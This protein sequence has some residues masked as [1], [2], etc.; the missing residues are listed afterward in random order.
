MSNKRANETKS[1]LH[2]W[3]PMVVLKFLAFLAF[4][5]VLFKATIGLG[6]QD[7]G[8]SRAW[9]IVAGMGGL[10]LLLAIDRL[11]GLKLSPTGMEATLSETKVQALKEVNARVEAPNV[12]KK[13][14]VD[15]LQAQHPAQVQEAVQEAVKLNVIQTV[16]AVEEAIRGKHK[17]YVRYR[18]DPAK[19]V[20][21]YHIAPRE[22]KPGAT[23]TTRDNDYLWAYS[24]EHESII[25]LRLDRVVG[26]E[27]SEETFDPAKMAAK[28][29]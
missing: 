12:V 29:E 22:I 23:Q 26:V 11:T 17:C 16:E 5:F 28:W 19:P 14:Q 4:A 21:T 18:P 3:L 8:S 9:I 24:Y 27:L 25:S 13:A 7:L 2:E 20:Q 1:S 15:I 6:E 10:L